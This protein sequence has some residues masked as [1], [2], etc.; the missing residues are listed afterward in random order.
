MSSFGISGTNAHL[1]L[2]EP[3]PSL[4]GSHPRTD[5]NP[6]LSE[7]SLLPLPL[8]LSARSLPALGQLA[9]RWASWWSLHPHVPLLHV[10]HTAASHRSALNFRASVLAHST[11][12]AIQSLFSLASGSSSPGLRQGLVRR[13][14][15]PVF[16][17]SGQGSQWHGMG[18]LLLRQNQ[19]F[20]QVVQLCDEALRP[21]TG[22]SVLQLLQDPGSAELP[23]LERVDV[24]Q[25]ALFTMNLA[26]A[27]MWLS[28][29]LQPQAVVGHSQ[30]EVA[31]AVFCGALTLQQGAQVV[32]C[33][34]QALLTVAGQGAMAVVEQ[35]EHQVD[36]MLQRYGGR[37]SVAVVNSESST[38]VSGDPE[39]IEHLLKELEA[40]GI[41]ARRVKVDYASHSAQMEQ[42][43][44]LVRQ[45][46]T[47]LEPKAG[48]LEFYS[49]VKGRA[50]GGEEL[51][52]EYWCQNLRNKV[53]YDE[54]RREL[55]SKGYGVF[56]EVSAHPVQS[57]G[58]GELGEEELVVSTLHRDRGGFDKVL[59]SAM[60][61]Y[62]A[63]VD[64]DLAQLGASGG[65]LVDL[66][67]YPFQRQRFWSD[68]VKGRAEISSLGLE[69]LKHPWLGA[70]TNLA[71]SDAKVFSGRL[72][73]AEQRWVE[74][75]RVHG[76][77]L[78]PG[79]CILDLA[80]AAA[81]AVGAP[82]VSE[83]T[84]AEPMLLSE[85][86]CLQVSVAAAS[87]QGRRAFSIYSR[88][89]GSEGP[90]TRHAVGSL[91]EHAPADDADFARL[92]VWPVPGTEQVDQEG[93][94]E[95]A[96][97]AGLEY[98]PAFRGLVELRRGQPA[99]EAFG[100]VVLQEGASTA[101]G[102]GVHPAL[103]DSALHTIFGA[104]DDL[105]RE[106]EVL[107]PFAWSD[108][109]L[110]PTDSREL[111][112]RVHVESEGDK[113]RA[114]LVVSDGAGRP[115]LRGTLELRRLGLAHLR[116]AGSSRVP[117]LYRTDHA[118]VV[119]PRDQALEGTVFV[120]PAGEIARSLGGE[121]VEPGELI[122]SL[123]KRD[124]APRRLVVDA[125]APLSGNVLHDVRC[126]TEAALSLLQQWLADERLADTETV[127]V[128]REASPNAAGPRD[129]ARAPLWGLLRSAQRESPERRVRLV[130]L[131]GG[132]LQPGALRRALLAADEPE[133]VLKGTEAQ[134]TRLVRAS[135]QVR[136]GWREL[137][138]NGTVL[139]TGGT[140]ELGRALARHLVTRHGVRHLLL[141][142]RQGPLTPGAQA[143][144]RELHE[145]GADTEGVRI[146][147]CDVTRQEDVAAALA[148][149]S[150]VHPLTGVIHLAGVLDDATIPNMDPA[151]LA[152]VLAPKVDGA[153]LL[154][155]L[156]AGLELAAF[157]LYA[158]T[159]GVLG[160][161]GQSNY[162][163]ANTFVE[164]LAVHRRAHGLPATS[165]AWGLWE[166]DG[167]GMTAHL[168]QAELARLRR[169]GVE[170]LRVREALGLFDLALR[171]P[172]PCLVPVNLAI[173][174]LQRS[175]ERSGHVP[176]LFR[177]LLKAPRAARLEAEPSTLTLREQLAAEPEEKRLASLSDLVCQE[178]AATVNL[179]AADAIKPRQALTELGLDSLMAVELRNRLAQRSG[180]S[181]PATLVFD[182]PTPWA[183]AQLVLE[184]MKLRRA[185]DGAAAS[186]PFDAAA[187]ARGAIP[188]VEQLNAELDALLSVDL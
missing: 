97:A 55:R 2:E 162:A 37:L 11:P 3:S 87:E 31:A 9:F 124:A 46:L 38:V 111:R 29:G 45:G 101:A 110:L 108:V 19:R 14:S 79:T 34:S 94:Y 109:V 156:T 86:L 158:S 166:P 65:Q 18:T 15:K 75:H 180:V 66:P 142:S 139:I 103:L 100:R 153:L 26:L 118:P 171:H 125:T 93:Y 175:A 68:G 176:P 120:G 4:Q 5:P 147:A 107:V 181:L 130:D 178:V 121:I 163:A 145:A 80:F 127:W 70:V 182:H 63:G 16:V 53:R 17:F 160:A 157:V 20:L 88:P 96:A 188:T 155:E 69:P 50:L 187:A 22:W 154:H 8:V 58:M 173:A 164:A 123:D 89:E 49:T 168:G 54:A 60:E 165:L 174:S 112:V 170:P 81:H 113:A 48:T 83:L 71:E 140:G 150:P 152:R 43:L 67:P 184:R 42:V 1:I 134:A 148:S 12:Q 64:L 98:G 144:I 128:T 82:T 78:V 117:H 36:Q 72:V 21:L 10:V 84:L 51:D 169:M 47:G 74:D 114:R 6:A 119:L 25:P 95:R 183:I 105:A 136:A 52:A 24:V 56:V 32:A 91:S 27:H 159:S 40:Q 167:T 62:V 149:I 161:A 151:R 177:G 92:A 28:L 44:P 138:R 106:G 172:E 90:W 76:L 186:S 132:T 129:L 143:L 137:D 41:F 104:V 135:E 57:L 73:A 131:L 85:P 126:V 99:A 116:A 7:P 23:P 102:Y 13:P 61:L 59:E 146:V 30:G 179:P 185:G 115:V 141:T 77:V 33:R 39:A 133:L 122:A 35:P